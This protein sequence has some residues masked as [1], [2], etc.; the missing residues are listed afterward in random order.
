[1]LSNVFYPDIFSTYIFHLNHC[2]VNYYCV[3][4]MIR[5]FQT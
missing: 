4:E 3:I 1:M 5:L 2:N